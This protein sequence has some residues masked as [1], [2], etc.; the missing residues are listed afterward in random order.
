MSDFHLVVADD[1]KVFTFQAD[2]AFYEADGA[3]HFSMI[4]HPNETLC[5]SFAAGRWRTY[6]RAN[7]ADALK[8]ILAQINQEQWTARTDDRVH[9]PQP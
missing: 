5:A 1:G 7:D 3:L 4:E 9:A 2:R 8:I 6:L